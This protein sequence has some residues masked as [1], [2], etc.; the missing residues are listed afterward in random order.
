VRDRRV[1]ARRGPTLCP[2][3]SSC[4]RNTEPTIVDLTGAAPSG[5]A[6]FD[7]LVAYTQAAHDAIVA[8]QQVVVDFI[9]ARVLETNQAFQN[10]GV[11]VTVF[12]VDTM[13]VPET[14]FQE[15]GSVVADANA[16]REGSSL[17]SVRQQRKTLEADIVVMLTA[18]GE[19]GVCGATNLKH[20]TN[21]LTA[22]VRADT[23][24]AAVRVGGAECGGSSLLSSFMPHEIAHMAGLNHARGETFPLFPARPY[25][26]GYV[27]PGVQLFRTIMAEQPGLAPEQRAPRILYFSNPAVS[28]PPADPAAR[29]TG[30]AH[31]AS[32]S[33]HA[34][35]ALNDERFLVAG[36]GNCETF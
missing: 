6:R 36:F 25:G 9:G 29:P 16:L 26:W 8:T 19:F 14:T 17:A 22:L 27:E 2:D 35:R 30:I 13:L 33:A 11:D 12:L 10:S 3:L 15:T 1:V 34:Q 21:N 20:R 32:N 4:E 28:Y 23:A 7:L 31:P 24:Y 5:Q 18:T